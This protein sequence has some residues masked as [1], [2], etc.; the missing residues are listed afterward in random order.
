M[1]ISLLNYLSEPVFF[2]GFIIVVGIAYV[3]VWVIS[4]RGLGG[5]YRTTYRFTGMRRE[6]RRENPVNGWRRGPG[7][8]TVRVKVANSERVASNGRA[9]V[10]RANTR[11]A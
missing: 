3:L 4:L 5:G 8:T 10:V 9:R 11:A 1:L 6:P 2:A 7:R